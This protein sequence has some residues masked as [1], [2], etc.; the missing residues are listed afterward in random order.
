VGKIKSTTELL[1]NA[2]TFLK[3]PAR[4]DEHIIGANIIFR[5]GVATDSGNESNMSQRS[6]PGKPEHWAT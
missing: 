5:I 3:C 2:P 1:G 4:L 6:A